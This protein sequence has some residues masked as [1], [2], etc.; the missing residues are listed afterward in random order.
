MVLWYCG[1]VI[2]TTLFIFYFEPLQ[3]PVSAHLG[4]VLG[5][6]GGESS[7]LT[8][9]SVLPGET[10]PG[11]SLAAAELLLQSEYFS[12]NKEIQGRHYGQLGGGW[13][14]VGTVCTLCIV[15]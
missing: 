9:Q 2:I 6:P 1:T 4:S 7:G 5:R 10:Q 12:C 13:W 8:H 11:L 14:V 3:P 15:R